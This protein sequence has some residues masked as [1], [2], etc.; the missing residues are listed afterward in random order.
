MVGKAKSLG[1][2]HPEKPVM[3]QSYWEGGFR[4]CNISEIT[5]SL[6]SPITRF[7]PFL[8]FTS[9]SELP[10]LG[11]S[12]RLPMQATKQALKLEGKLKKK[13]KKEKGTLCLLNRNAS[14][15]TRKTK[16]SSISDCTCCDY[17]K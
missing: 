13:K 15:E 1:M 9:F 5:H 14:G 4:Y 7:P 17:R 6:V 8:P 11:S 3:T 12:S 10:I 2:D 16:S